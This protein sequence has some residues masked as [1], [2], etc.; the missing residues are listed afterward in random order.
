MLQLFSA[1]PAATTTVLS[2]AREVYNNQIE[3]F[4]FRLDTLVLGFGQS[5][6]VLI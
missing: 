2:R 1:K 5:Y 4:L 6:N 3:F